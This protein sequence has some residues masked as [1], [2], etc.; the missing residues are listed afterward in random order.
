MRVGD[1]YVHLARGFGSA[2]TAQ[3]CDGIRIE[4]VTVH[5]S[6]GLAVGLVGN[7]GEI[8]VRGLQVRFAPDSTGCSRPTRTACTASRTAADR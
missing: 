1:A 3:G 8:V 6:P 4:N 7:R 2:V 5:A